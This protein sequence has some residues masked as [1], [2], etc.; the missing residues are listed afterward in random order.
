MSSGPD[1]T[2]ED[3]EVLKETRPLGVF[4]IEQGVLTVLPA[5]HFASER[6]ARGAIEPYLKAW[7][8]DAALRKG[9][10]AIRFQFQSAV[11][12]DRAR[13]PAGHVS[14]ALAAGASVVSGIAGHLTVGRRTYPAPP[15]A[16]ELTPDLGS[17][18]QRLDRYWQERTDLL[19][20][21]Y[22]VLSMVEGSGSRA[23]AAK[24]LKMDKKIL[25]AIGT[26]TSERG[27]RDSARKF[28]DKGFVELSAAE[29]YW[30]EE[31]LR[32]LVLRVGEH[33]AGVHLE[34]I[35]LRISPFRSLGGG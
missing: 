30:L 35:S 16:F 9:P 32:W 33:E 17:A 22:F 7:E 34:P 18:F 24:K 14:I 25:A 15:T 6:D 2:Y 5:Q 13:R 10:G 1:V 28:S 11:V 20:V 26:L 29:R 8:A 27:G 3:P 21:G 23:D 4:M 12:V 19:S 31:A